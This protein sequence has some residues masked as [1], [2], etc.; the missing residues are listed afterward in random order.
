M[1][2]EREWKL[3]SAELL[4]VKIDGP[5]RQE[6][7]DAHIGISP[8]E[9]HERRSQMLHTERDRRVDA[10]QPPRMAGRGGDLSRE[11]LRELAAKR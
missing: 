1:M 7:A 3:D 2:M 8:V 5:V 4:G 9:L 6:H 10:Q 11:A